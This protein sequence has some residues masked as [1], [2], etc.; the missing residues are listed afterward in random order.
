VSECIDPDE[1]Q[2]GELAAYI[3]DDLQAELPSSLARQDRERVRTHLACCP[4]CAAQAEE[5]RR[6]AAQMHAVLYR[7]SCPAPE[8]LALYQL[9]L[10]P[11][12]ERL[13]LA[14][15]VRECPHCQQELEELARE[16][17]RPS[18][19][20]KLHQAAQTL[21]AALVPPPSAQALGL[22]GRGPAMQRFRLEDLDVLVSVQPGHSRGQ[23][24]LEGRLLPQER[25]DQVAWGAEVWLLQD[26]EAVVAPIEAR[27][28][29]SF[30]DVEP[31]TYRLGFEWHNQAVQTGEIDVP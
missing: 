29:F 9:S 12:R 22:R 10:L 20:H 7:A 16:P 26:Q 21:E 11:A 1:L 25:A 2:G 13:S 8:E 27:G 5:L 24:R 23:R 6:V 19:L 3:E 4:H 17:D 28:T 14:Q 31:G 30:A 15:H 18:L